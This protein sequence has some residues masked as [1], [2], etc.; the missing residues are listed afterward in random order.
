MIPRFNLY[1]DSER[2][3]GDIQEDF[4]GRWAKWRDIEDYVI[5][6][7][8]HGFIPTPEVIVPHAL[9]TM[10]DEVQKQVELFDEDDLPLDDETEDVYDFMTR[11]S[12]ADD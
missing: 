6:A 4:A 1:G 8:E 12:R 2:W 3:K 5:Y 7:I 9:L 11:A 10:T